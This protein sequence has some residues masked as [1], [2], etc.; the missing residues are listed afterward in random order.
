MSYTLSN[1]AAL[2]RY[3]ED[4]DLEIDNNGANA[5]SGICGVM[6]TPGLCRAGI[7][8]T[9]RFRRISDSGGSATRHNH[10][11]SRKA[12]SESG[13]RK[14]SGTALDGVAC[15]SAFSLSRMSA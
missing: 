7:V 1:W 8:Q 3:C 6:P 2:V 10:R 14:R 5:A 12:S 9:L 15:A 13:G 11:L 4:G